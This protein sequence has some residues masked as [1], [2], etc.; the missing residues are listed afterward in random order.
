MKRKD[1][2]ANIAPNLPQMPGCYMFLD[3]GGAVL[4]VGKSNCLKKRVSSYF[5][6]NKL[7]KFNVMLRFADNIKV[8]QTNTDIEALLLEFELIKKHRPQYNAKMRKDYQKWYLRFDDGVLLTLDTKQTG[9]FVGPFSHKETALEALDILGKCFRLPTCN[10]FSSQTSRMCMRGHLKNCIAPCENKELGR[11][12]YQNAIKF[13]QGNYEKTLEEVQKKMKIAIKNMEYEKAAVYKSLI[14]LMGFIKNTA[15]IL[16]KKRFVVYLKS[17]HEDCFML[18]FLDDGVCLAKVVLGGLLETDK[19]QAFA[20][21]V[22]GASDKIFET[23]EENKAFVRAIVEISAIRR[24][25]E[26]NGE[27]IKHG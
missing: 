9:F 24:F 18:A 3:K 19:I 12:I 21:A 20:N 26:I 10:K 16:D 8:Q 13:L 17:R 11:G 4:Y 6:K 27:C 23:E 5:G 15:P 22:Q 1:F 25:F 14:Q 2:L 7:K